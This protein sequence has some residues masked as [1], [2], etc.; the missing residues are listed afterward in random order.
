MFDEIVGKIGDWHRLNGAGLLIVR[1]GNLI[2]SKVN[3]V[4]ILEHRVPG[5]GDKVVIF[6]YID[7][8]GHYEWKLRSSSNGLNPSNVT[9]AM[10]WVTEW[11]G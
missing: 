9:Q 6:Q 4:W 7:V 8:G 10:A 2:V 5:S 1:V 3:Y 11:L